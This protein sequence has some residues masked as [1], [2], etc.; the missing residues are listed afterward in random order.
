MRRAKRTA[1]GGLGKDGAALAAMFLTSGV[2]HFVRPEPFH[3]MVPNAL[4]ARR[5]LVYI[6]GAAEIVCGLGLLSR[7]TRRVAGL[8]SA[9]LL[10][11]IFPANLTM[12]GQAKRRFDRDPRNAQKRGYLA[13]AVVRLPLQWPMIRSA[14]RAAGVWR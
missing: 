2:M 11:G 9:A 13:A 1:S 3:A 7:S 12:A 6:S 8:A 4:P 10:V 14:L 5:L